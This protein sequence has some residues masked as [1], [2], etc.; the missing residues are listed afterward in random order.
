MNLQITSMSPEDWPEVCDIYGQGIAT[1]DATFEIDT[2]DWQRWDRE[3]LKDCRLMARS[4]ERILGWAALRPVS[5]RQVYTGVAEVSIY[6]ATAAHGQGI[7]KA[8]LSELVRQSESSGIWTLQAGIFPENVASV[9]LHKACGFRE[10]GV[11]Q[12]VG[13]LDSRWRDVV[14]L[15]RRSHQVGV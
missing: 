8:L 5:N 2:P 14:L 10:V 15:E 11:R 9:A 3:H 6:V 13:K 4:D 1:G 7:G 12:R